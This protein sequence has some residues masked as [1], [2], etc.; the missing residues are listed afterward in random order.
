M[1]GNRCRHGSSRSLAIVNLDERSPWGGLAS[2][3][4]RRQ[5]QH[6]RAGFATRFEVD[7]ELQMPASV[8]VGVEQD[9]AERPLA[10]AAFDSEPK[11]L[12]R[13]NTR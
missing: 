13:Q 11:D 10:R 2:V 4:D 3:A 7:F 6:W 5:Q 8:L 12:E 1:P 9:L